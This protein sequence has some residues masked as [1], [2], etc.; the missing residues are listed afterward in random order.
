MKRALG[1]L[2]TQEA[3][4]AM[5]RGG[6][7]KRAEAKRLLAEAKLKGGGGSGAAA[8]AAAAGK[9]AGGGGAAGS[10]GAAA[11]AAAPPGGEGG[12]GGDWRLRAPA[13][14]REMP[15]FKPGAVTWDT[16]DHTA[17]A[18]AAAKAS[19]ARKKKGGGGGSGGGGGAAGPAAGPA[20]GPGGGDAGR[21]AG[22][23]SPK[24]WYEAAGR[25]KYVAS[26][27]TT[28]A[29][30]RAFTSTVSVAATKNERQLVRR[31]LST[32]KKGYARLHTNL[33]DIN[34]ELHCDVAPRTCENFL[35]LCE[36][37]YY[38]GVPFHRSI[39]NFMI[40]V[41][42]GGGVWGRRAGGHGDRGA[43]G[44]GGAPAGA[45]ALGAGARSGQVRVWARGASGAAAPPLTPLGSPPPPPRAAPRRA[46]PA[47]RRPHRHRHGRREHLRSVLQGRA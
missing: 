23:P 2:G 8:K 47:G 19:A 17:A 35:A 33:G 15:T 36:M 25:V 5:A 12:G 16:E 45:H 39:K 20:V 41:G 29:M 4:D 40:Q 11:A 10:A 7:G 27:L 1:A 37:G 28:G 31:E 26:H 43:T 13:A 44:S 21:N 34:L 22:K 18:E 32:D 6:G 14:S 46:P 3:A 42:W 38:D 30:S 24:E 9:P